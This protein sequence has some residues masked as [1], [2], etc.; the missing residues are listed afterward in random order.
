[1][2]TDC[3]KDNY[4]AIS[5]LK[6]LNKYDSYF[7]NWGTHMVC[8]LFRIS[9]GILLIMNI[10]YYEQFRPLFIILIVLFGIKSS[11]LAWNKKQNWKG[12]YRTIIALLT[13]MCLSAQGKNESGGMVLIVDALISMQSRYTYY[14]INHC[15]SKLE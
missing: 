15:L 11:Y 14:N 4:T 12:Y 1:M 13:S 6:P 2:S 3:L 5:F 8:I 9:L 7:H 10:E